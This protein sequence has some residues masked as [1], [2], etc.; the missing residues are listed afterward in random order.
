MSELQYLACESSEKSRQQKVINIDCLLGMTE[1]EDRSVSRV[2]TDHPY[3]I[4]GMGDDW[5][6]KSLNKRAAKAGVVGGLPVGMKFDKKQS[7]D[8]SDFMNPIVEEWVRVVKP[9][10]FILCFM[11]PRLSHVVAW[12]MDR[13]GIEIRDLFLWKKAGQAKAFTQSHFVRKN[14][15]LSEDE[16]NTMLK[17]LGERKTPQLRPMGETII[18]GQLPK[19]GTFV[20]NFLKYGVGLIDTSNPLLDPYHFPSS[21]METPPPKIKYGHLTPKPVD[22]LRHLIR[23]FGGNAPLILDPFAGCG[24]GGVAAVKEGCDF[25]GYEIENKYAEQAN[26]RIKE[27]NLEM[28][29]NFSNEFK[30]A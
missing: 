30:L 25:I 20:D 7:D 22:L 18:L 24:S 21:I 5:D 28:E 27:A 16:K 4:D 10:G 17:R 26:I 6:D 23:I 3:F 2:I 14:K 19:E 9:G 29:E 13:A 1:L 8:L 12:A 15:N 11:Q